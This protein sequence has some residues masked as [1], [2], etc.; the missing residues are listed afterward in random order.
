MTITSPNI[1]HVKYSLLIFPL[2]WR[3]GTGLFTAGQIGMAFVAINPK[4]PDG[5][6]IDELGYSK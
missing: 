2:N 1:C 6:S 3:T 5:L 4:Q